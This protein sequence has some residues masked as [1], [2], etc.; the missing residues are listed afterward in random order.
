MESHPEP[1]PFTAPWR[2]ELHF[3]CDPLG[4][5][6]ARAT[7]HAVLA[8]HGIG[9]LAEKAALLMTELATNSVQHCKGSAL[10]T[11]L[12]LCPVLRVSVWDRGPDLP[13]FG[14]PVVPEPYADTGRGL[15]ILDA[16]ADRWGGCGM[17]EGP[18]GPG[19]KTVWFELAAPGP[20]RG[21]AAL[22]A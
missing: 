10:V 9:E 22:A 7:L 6:V 3:P 4:P 11:L 15:L 17:E 21:G 20:S 1:I 16:L 14:T 18:R 2:Y 12:W 8:A 13:P 19:G 5:G